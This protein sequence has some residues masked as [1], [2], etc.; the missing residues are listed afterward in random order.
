[1]QSDPR[2]VS[3]GIWPGDSREVGGFRFSGRSSGCGFQWQDALLTTMGEVAERYCPAFYDRSKLVFSSYRGLGQPAIHPGELALYH[4]QQYADFDFP[5]I[6]FTED[7]EVH[8]TPCWDLTQGKEVLFPGSMVYIPWVEEEEWIAVTS[9]TGMAGHTDLYRA[10]LTGLYENIERDSFVITW[11]Q[12]MDAPKIQISPEIRQF[13][14][15]NFP[16][17]YEFHFLDV[18]YDLGVP[19]VFG[20]CFGEA[21]FGKF[22]AVGSAAR[23]TYAEALIKVAAEIGQAVSYFR[24]LLGEMK[25]WIPSDDFN[26]I[27]NFEEHSLF[28]LKRPDLWHV[29]DQW[30]YKEATRQIDFRERRTNEA[31]EEIRKVT[32]KLAGLGYNVLIKNLTTP[33]VKQAGFFS[34]RVIVP[35]L[36]E[37]AGSYQFYFNGGRRLFETPAKLG[38]PVK[39][40]EQLNPYPHPFP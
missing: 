4:E 33:D 39:C 31:D 34:V 38:Y 7:T 18:N 2:L 5:L 32:Q 3:F 36:L 17:N 30:R 6:P 15:E 1:M 29:F 11:M 9:S 26:E 25:G 22:V 28:Y 19:A 37:M 40:Y 14:S 16:G 10:I 24:Y 13:L 8:W 35:Q 12:Q 27:M 20:F 21:D 23:G